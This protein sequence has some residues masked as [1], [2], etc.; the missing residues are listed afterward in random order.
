MKNTMLDLASNAVEDCLIFAVGVSPAA[1]M[2]SA[3]FTWSAVRSS[4]NSPAQWV[5]SRRTT[6]RKY[7]LPIIA[8]I[9]A[10]GLR[11][12]AGS[13]RSV[14]QAIRARAGR[15][16]LRGHAHLHGVPDR[17]DAAG[18]EVARPLQGDGGG[19]EKATGQRLPHGREK[20]GREPGL[21]DIAQGPG[22][23]GGAD[24]VRVRVHGQKD[25]PGQ[26]TRS[27]QL[28]GRLDT[29][30]HGHR[31]VEHHDVRLEPGRLVQKRLPIAD[32][33]DHLEMRFEM[34]SSDSE[35]ILVVIGQQ[36]CKSVHA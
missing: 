17:P 32:R 18:A 2:A 4:L 31:D 16:A 35:E 29:V 23:E 19:H 21:E 6:L 5:T 15:A 14:L 34:S 25:D 11:W 10:G 1:A 3:T 36:D 22:G 33:L 20:I 9:W 26:G 27:P 7:L 12:P 24:I 30:Q 13:A 28:L 8:V